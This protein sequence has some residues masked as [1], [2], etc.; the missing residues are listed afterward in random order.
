[1]KTAIFDL[2]GTL[3]DTLF[4]LADAVNEGLKTLGFPVHP[5]EP[6][7]H[8]VGNGAMKLCERALPDGKKE[9]SEELH[10]LFRENYNR[11]YLDKTKLYD[12]IHE[13]LKKLSEN[14]VVL[15]VATNKP[16]NFAVKMI[17]NLLSDINFVKVLGGTDSRPKKPEKPIIDEILS[18][19][20]ETDEVYMIGDSNVDVQTAKK[21]GLISI[22]CTWGFREREELIDEG[23]DYIA[24]TPSDIAEIILKS[25]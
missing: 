12:G 14:G 10:R 13:T 19:V 20:G 11:N 22:G 5:Y 3:A 18:A 7:R 9:F 21:S 6:Y 15:A 16:E 24:E 25:K 1:M 4:D 2:D 8:F 23:A 17:D